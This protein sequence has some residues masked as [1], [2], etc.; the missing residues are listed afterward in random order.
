M[1]QWK[2]TLEEQICGAELMLM[3]VLLFRI[4]KHQDQ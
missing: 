1:L 2:R 3:T 4:H